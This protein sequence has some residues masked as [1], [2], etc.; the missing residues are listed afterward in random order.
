MN[1]RDG[2][3]VPFGVTRV[4]LVEYTIIVTLNAHDGDLRPNFAGSH[5]Q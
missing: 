2:T 5:V 3:K 1:S 4:L